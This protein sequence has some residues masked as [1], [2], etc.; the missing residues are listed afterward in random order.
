MRMP[1]RHARILAED[2]RLDRD[3]H[4]VRRQADA[5]EVDVVEVAQRDAVQHQHLARDLQILLE[6]AADGLRHV[7]IQDEI[8]RLRRRDGARERRDHAFGKGMQP[9]ERRLAAP[10]ESERHLGLPLD[11]VEGGEML[12]DRRGNLARI[13]SARQVNVRLHHLQVLARQKL[14]R[15]RHVHRVAGELHAVLGG[16]ERGGAD[17]LAG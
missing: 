5:A 14:A 6:D 10:A 17:A 2:E 9:C 4:G 15:L 12:A 7:A 8:D 3:R 1:V 11:H 13:E 16:A